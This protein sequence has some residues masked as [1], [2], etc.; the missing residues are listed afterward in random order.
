M[1]IIAEPLAHVRNAERLTISFHIRN[2]ASTASLPCLLIVEAPRN[3]LRKRKQFN[4]SAVG[5]WH[6]LQKI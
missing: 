1:N 6:S 5:H 2:K 3:T 4:A